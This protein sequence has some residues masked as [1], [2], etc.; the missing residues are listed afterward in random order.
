MNESSQ[1]EEIISLHK[2]LP[3]QKK[4]QSGRKHKKKGKTTAM[5]EN[6]DAQRRELFT[7]KEPSK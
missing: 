6:E 4:I 1:T 3:L 7:C 2:K 5:D